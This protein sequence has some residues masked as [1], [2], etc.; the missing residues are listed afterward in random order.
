[1]AGQAARLAGVGDF[2]VEKIVEVSFTKDEQAMFDKSVDSVG[3]LVDACM[4]IAPN[5]S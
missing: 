5:L 2:G 4:K 1:M 3:G